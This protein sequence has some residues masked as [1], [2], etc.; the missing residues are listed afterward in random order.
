MVATYVEEEDAPASA[1]PSQSRASRTVPLL[2]LL[3]VAA[4]TGFRIWV[5]HPAWFFFDDFFFIEQARE[6]G[7]TADYLVTPYNGH[8]MPASW[9]LT[10]VNAKADPF[11]FGYPATE[12]VVMSA[13]VGLGLLRLLISLF[14]PR[15]GVLFPLV[16]ALFS[17]VLLPATTWWA[18]AVNLLPM[19]IS[20]TF[21][22]T[23]FVQHLRDRRTS[24]LVWSLAW[25]LLGL[26]FVERS[27]VVVMVMWLVAIMYFATGPVPHRVG[28][29]LRT[30]RTAVVAHGLLVPAYLAVYVV[31]AKNFDA[32]SVTSRP[33][34]GVLGYVAGIAFP[35]GATGGPLRWRVAEVTQSEA[36]PHQAVLILAWL[37][38]ATVVWAS[39]RTRH[40]GARAWLLPLTALVANA[41]LIAVSRAIYFGSEISL[42]FRFQTEVAV[43]LPLAV[44]LAFLPVVGAVESSEPKESGW[45][46]DTRATV[47]PAMAVFLVAAT[48][49]ASSFPL[50]NLTT[51]SPQRYV[52]TFEASARALPGRQVLDRPTPAYLWSPVAYPT[53]LASRILAPLAGL[54]D[55][56]SATT[57][58]AWRID[59]RGRLV[60]LELVESRSQTASVGD[61]GCFTTLRGGAV[62]SSALDGP[63]LG[64][65]WYVRIDYHASESVRLTLSVGD[66]SRTDRLEPGTHY[67]LAPAGGSYDAVRLEVPQGSAPVCLRHLGIVAVAGP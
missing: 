60:P 67:L 64:V 14:G 44:G 49:S 7:L 17:P 45:R 30:Y 35:S 21:G 23:A 42:D 25:L 5:I 43:L 66:T 59:D 65:D 63:V 54:V 34:F 46:L 16:L 12:I 18:A 52:E 4:A 37:V 32:Q 22:L 50:R 53:N 40:R 1:A 13:L 58:D 8:L 48:V 19:L 61:D 36:H 29:L 33:F 39:V 11:G 24:D 57:D 15:P 56:R 47:L 2:G 26:A 38:V 10:W 31:Y 6:K 51:T 27:L 3:V 62:S 9:L 55:F 20:L 41:L 28:H